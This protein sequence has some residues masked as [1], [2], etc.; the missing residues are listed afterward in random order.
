[1]S[2]FIQD[3]CVSPGWAELSASADNPFSRLAFGDKTPCFSDGVILSTCYLSIILIMA[4]RLGQVSGHKEGQRRFKDRCYPMFRALLVWCIF[5]LEVFNIA[6]FASPSLVDKVGTI[7][8][9]PTL[10]PFEAVSGG[11]ACLAWLVAA[12][13]LSLE[14]N[15][16]TLS[17]TWMENFS[18]LFCLL[19]LVV[20]IYVIQTLFPLGVN[21]PDDATAMQGPSVWFFYAYVFIT[22]ILALGP[23]FRSYHEDDLEPQVKKPGAGRMGGLQDPLL[24]SNVDFKQTFNFDS[25]IV[26]EGDA[27]EDKLR[28]SS[29]ERAC[30]C[31][32]EGYE[33]GHQLHSLSSLRCKSPVKAP[34]RK[35][36]CKS[37]VK[38]N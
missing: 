1:M 16:F 2:Q 29:I 18:F 35:R 36:K 7:Y 15:R 31:R 25:S 37:A 32:Q 11:L 5:F 28:R 30:C 6:K 21:G 24:T 34:K 3:Y 8:H 33:G 26:I 13:A 12:I 9:T 17:G 20:K 4:I 14:P 38:K 27:D 23:I 10:V 22:M 19:C